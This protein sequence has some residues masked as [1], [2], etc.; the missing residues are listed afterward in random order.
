MR[1]LAKSAR[2]ALKLHKKRSTLSNRTEVEHSNF[3]KGNTKE[4]KSHSHSQ[5][6][7]TKSVRGEGYGV[8]EDDHEE[9]DDD[10]IS[11]A[12]Q[13]D[14]PT[15]AGWT[16]SSCHSD[17]EWG[18]T[19]GLTVASGRAVGA[20]ARG[21]SGYGCGYGGFVSGAGTTMSQ[22]CWSSY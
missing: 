5:L 4:A 11:E 2:K 19:F 14:L 10:G 1:R 21:G 3:R 20:A 8:E 17:I 6:K 22:V 16:R 15:V 12:E 18:S 9:E 13:K 7:Y